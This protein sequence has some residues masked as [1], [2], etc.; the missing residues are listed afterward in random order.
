MCYS[1]VD[2]HD[3]FEP[4]PI[5][6]LIWFLIYTETL[7]HEE[8]K[9]MGKKPNMQ[10]MRV[11]EYLYVLQIS[12]YRSDKSMS[13]FSQTSGENDNTNA[14]H[15]SKLCKHHI[16]T[17]IKVGLRRTKDSSRLL[18]IC[19]FSRFHS[20]IVLTWWCVLSWF[21][22]HWKVRLYHLDTTTNDRVKIWNENSRRSRRSVREIK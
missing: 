11:Y 2:V 13:W 4:Y 17:C 14:L 12:P 10:C 6:N 3:V 22:K 1:C 8:G 5:F 20:R 16:E 19:F 15:T 7:K 21:D 9:E 18:I